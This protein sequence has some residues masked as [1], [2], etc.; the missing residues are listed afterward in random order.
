MSTVRTEPGNR[1]G[2]R[3]PGAGLAT[4]PPHPVPDIRAG[5]SR[6]RYPLWRVQRMSASRFCLG[7]LCLA[8]LSLHTK[9]IEYLGAGEEDCAGAGEEQEFAAP[10]R[11]LNE[12]GAAAFGRAQ[13]ERIDDQI[14]FEPRLDGE[15]PTDLAQHGHPFLNAAGCKPHAMNGFSR[16]AKVNRMRIVSPADDASSALTQ[17]FQ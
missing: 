1:I 2:N 10:S 3:G 9:A 15:K 16:R 5:A 6:D 17:F 12:I 11:K 8:P 13:A 7:C 4:E 14:G